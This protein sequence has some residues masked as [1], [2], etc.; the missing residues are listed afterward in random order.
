[1]NSEKA[2]RVKLSA[3]MK[4]TE[5]GGRAPQPGRLAVFSHLAPIEISDHRRHITVSERI[6][7]GFY[8]LWV[9]AAVVAPL[10]VDARRSGRA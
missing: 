3:R 5:S 7:E 4:P 6:R 9:P 10:R 8:P 1:M 2:E